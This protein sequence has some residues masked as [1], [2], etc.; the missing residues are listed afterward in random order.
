MEQETLTFHEEYT[1][2][3]PFIWLPS[4]E[5]AQGNLYSDCIEQYHLLKFVFGLRCR[6]SF[7]HHSSPNVKEL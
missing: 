6:H 2:E 5:I 1:I 4:L 7:D 3:E